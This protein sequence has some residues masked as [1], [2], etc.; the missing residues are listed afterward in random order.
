MPSVHQLPDSYLH[1]ELYIGAV[2][3]AGRSGRTAHVRNPAS[4]RRRANQVAS[5]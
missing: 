3:H 5:A 2:L 1:T 4:D